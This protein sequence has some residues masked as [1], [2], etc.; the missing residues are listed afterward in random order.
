MSAHT[1]EAPP[2]ED[3]LEPIER[4][5]RDLRSQ[6][7]G[8][9]SREAAR[10]LTAHGPNELVRH[11][12]ATWPGEVARQLV[13]PLALLLWLAAGLAA[14]SGTRAL[15]LAIAAV[16]LLNAVVAFVQERQAER[17][18]DAL[19]RYLPPRATVLRDGRRRVVEAREL[20]PGD[21]LVVSEGERISADARLVSGGVE[22]DLSA[23]T[24]ESAPVFR[25]ADLLDAH[26]SPLQARDL[27]F[28]GTICTGG[29]ATA[30]VHA[31]GMRTELGRIATLSQRGRREPS[32]LEREVTRVAWLIAAIAVIAGFAFLVLGLLVT[33]LPLGDAVQFAIGLLVANVP[34]GLLPTITLALAVGVRSLSR[35]GA[36]VKRLSAVETLG[37]STV[38][39]TDKTG[40]L[41]EN[42]MRPVSAWTRGGTVDLAA[43]RRAGEAPALARLARRAAA[44]CTAVVAP[45]PDG[46]SGDPTE[47]AVLEAAAALGADLD[48]GEREA[49]RRAVYRF[50]PALR[51]MTTVDAADGRLWVSTKGAP[52]A[53]LARATSILGAD[54]AERPIEDSDAR[55]VLHEVEGLARRGLRVLAIADRVLP[56]ET[57]A[58]ARRE[59][60]ERGLC[61]LGLLAMRDP[62]RATVPEAV[63]RCRAAGLR[64]IVVT[65]DNGVTAA[66][67]AREVGIVGR[68]PLIVSGD[69]LARMGDGELER[70]LA[71]SPE[72]IFARSDP[73]AKLRIADA[74]RAQGEVV[75]MTGDGVNDAPAL[76]HADIGVAM[77]RS[78]TD[79]A[80]EAATMILTDDDFA[81]VVAAVEEGRRVYQNVRR[82]VLYIFAHAPPEVVPFLVFALSGGAVPLPLTVMQILAIDL[83]TET[84]PALALGRERAEP[85]VMERPPRRRGQRLVDRALLARAWGAMGLMSAALVMGG[86]FFELLGAGWSPGDPVEAGAPLH[87]AYMQATTIAFLGIV[88]CQVGTA[89]AARTDRVTLARVG[90]FSNHLLLWGIAFEIAFSAALVTIPQMQELFGTAIPSAGA[91]G[92]LLAFPVLVWGADELWRRRR[93]IPEKPAVSGKLLG[94]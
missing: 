92:L 49:R 68:E 65:G 52:E 48:E 25:A 30:L 73:E 27:V 24:G 58:P 55:A 6:P 46:E 10:R 76:R 41:T 60:A 37:S 33:R 29:E 47:I 15:A 63:A 83:G 7:E 42:R 36:L 59:E 89:M 21:M 14:L 70:M 57:A 26:V 22:V 20:V 75:A 71:E 86:F 31:T 81:S 51:M 88:A 64:V 77:G 43:R 94:S 11:E 66:A 23:L 82:F 32:A 78:G 19:R 44:C 39:C 53:L 45:G 79:V 9:S 72:L 13:H 90:L 62:P 74:L 54:G 38:I 2:P 56:A 5:F 69:E 18:V 40:T 3:P 16:I 85:D 61:F 34:E 67:I 4:L 87:Q 50:D 84:L 93:P 12:G 8:L 28:S 80:R 17:A 91:L 35:R 1:P